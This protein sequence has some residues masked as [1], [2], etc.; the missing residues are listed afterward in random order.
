MNVA[1]LVMAAAAFY[2]HG[3]TNIQQ[4]NQA[5]DILKPLFGPLAAIIFA[6]TLLASG[7]ASSVVGTLAGQE[8]MTSML[9]VKVNPYLRRV[10]TRVVNVFPTTICI[11][12]GISPLAL[13]FYSQVFLSIL[14][15]L[16]MIPLIW[17]TSKK[18]I[19][20]SF[21]NRRS[22]IIMALVVGIVIIA[23]NIALIYTSI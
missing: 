14:I 1:I 22:T 16:P 4:I 18:K 10:I 20:G 12:I 9:G 19:M 17:Y 13:L 6:I 3:Y 2:G 21:V 15:P 11:L 7:I 8:L 23:L 5:F